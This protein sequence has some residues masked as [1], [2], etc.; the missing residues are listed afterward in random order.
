MNTAN[1]TQVN[2]MPMMV[3]SGFRSPI[4]NIHEELEKLKLPQVIA[5]IAMD[6]RSELY[7]YS[8]YKIMSKLAEVAVL[9][10]MY[11]SMGTLSNI[12]PLLYQYTQQYL[13]DM[14]QITQVTMESIIADLRSFNPDTKGSSLPNLIQRFKGY[15]AG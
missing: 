15:L 2:N 6:A 8:L 9:K 4:P 5:E 1:N 7:G 3:P 14:H 11:M 10:Q 12:E 13:I